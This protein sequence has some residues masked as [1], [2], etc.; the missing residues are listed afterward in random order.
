M[1][2]MMMAPPLPM[3]NAVESAKTSK[4]SGPSPEERSFAEYVDRKAASERSKKNLLGASDAAAKKVAGNKTDKGEVSG[5][6]KAKAKET[7]VDSSD[8]NDSTDASL[9]QKLMRKLQ[10]I[11]AEREFGPG[12]W[13]CVSPDIGILQ[14]I[15]DAVG[16]GDAEFSLLLEKMKQDDGKLDLM[17]FFAALE[18]HFQA[19]DKP[20][21]IT[22]PETVLPL[23]ETLLSRMSVPVEDIT[24]ISEQAVT[25]DDKLDIVLFLEG[26][27][28]LA[29]MKEAGDE[30][31][32]TLS[33][34]EAEQLK[35]ML[36]KAGVSE[37]LQKSLFLE[38]GQTPVK[39]SLGRLQDML[40]QAIAE[41]ESNMP[42]ADVPAFL[43]ELE[44]MLARA[45]FQEKGPGWSPVVQET[46]TALYQ[47]LR[48]TVDLAT[49]KVQKGT[50]AVIDE[51]PEEALVE[52]EMIEED[53]LAAAGK[54][55]KDKAG[56]SFA[57]DAE[58][59][60]FQS[61]G[62]HEEAGAE[63]VH[64]EF[65]PGSYPDPAAN[66][67]SHAD[68]ARGLAFGQHMTRQM[69]QQAFDQI[70]AGVMRGLRNN[71]HH[72]VLKLHPPELGEV[73]V[74]LHVRN[75]QI[76][77]SF[78]MENSR[79]KEVLQSNMEQFRDSL[80]QKGFSL[81]QCFVSVDQ[82]DQPGDSWQRFENIAKHSGITIE[83]LTDLP[84]DALYLRAVPGVSRDGGVNLFV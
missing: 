75:E 50:A 48:K 41:V 7:G 59:R 25:G 42:Q 46:I 16:M 3:A 24:R 67:A 1:N 68:K 29:E 9:L 34:W 30:K 54:D 18:R 43:T 15:K 53:G 78:A 45:G 80:E 62:K 47:E 28:T 61:Q 27:N 39:F 60:I 32:I 37:P 12:A 23:L 49:V 2:A 77:V 21:P 22:V 55:Q 65:Q 52:E 13:L 20:R 36:D 81:G 8:A 63:Q 66:M 82:Q 31:A 69:Q 6:A 10:D 84:D 38:Q 83:K 40:S 57:G 72:L 71:E 11:A 51:M 56:K 73:K 70:A 74:D 26:L 14:E 19:L 4:K 76:S 5:R 33:A 44:N 35:E 58:G 79:V 64:T 17:D